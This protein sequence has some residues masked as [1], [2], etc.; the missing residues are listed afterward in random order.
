MKIKK[1]KTINQILLHAVLIVLIMLVLPMLSMI[2][3]SLIN[4]GFIMPD[5]PKILPQL[6]FYFKNYTDAWN[7]SNFKTYL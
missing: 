6:P 1:G 5:P 2:T 3:N 7:G 4:E